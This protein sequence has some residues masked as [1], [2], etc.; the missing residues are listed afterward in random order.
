MEIS[1]DCLS[2][3]CLLIDGTIFCASRLVLGRQTSVLAMASSCYD[4]VGC[5]LYSFV[6]FGVF[7]ELYTRVA[8]FGFVFNFH[9]LLIIADMETCDDRLFDILK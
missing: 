5:Y 4:L 2:S 3:L 6:V 1:V 7:F 9:D 8:G